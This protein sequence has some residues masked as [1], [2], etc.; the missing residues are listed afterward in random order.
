MRSQIINNTI[1]WLLIM[2]G[3]A[4]TKRSISQTQVIP[5]ESQSFHGLNHLPHRFVIMIHVDSHEPKNSN[6]NISVLMFFC[7]NQ[8]LRGLALGVSQLLP[9]AAQR[10]VHR[11]IATASHG[12][13]LHGAGA[14]TQHAEDIQMDLGTSKVIQLLYQLFDYIIVILTAILTEYV[15]VINWMLTQPLFY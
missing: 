11:G 13:P 6:N 14:A 15:F 3:A 2:L 4:I 5:S 10:R 1:H 9:R 7:L 8:A 12:Q